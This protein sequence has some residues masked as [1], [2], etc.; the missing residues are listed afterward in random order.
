[1]LFSE[2]EIERLRRDALRE[3]EE[4]TAER[5]THSSNGFCHD[6][7]GARGEVHVLWEGGEGSDLFRGGNEFWEMYPTIN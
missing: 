3:G 5:E 7:G 2:E 1:M 6:P 4:R